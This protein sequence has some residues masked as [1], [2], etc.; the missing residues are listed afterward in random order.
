[1]EVSSS[2]AVPLISFVALVYFLIKLVV[3]V[4][5]EAFGVAPVVGFGV[6]AFQQRLGVLWA[7]IFW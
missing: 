5:M 6:L 3:Q 4:V 7:G 2:L 1:M